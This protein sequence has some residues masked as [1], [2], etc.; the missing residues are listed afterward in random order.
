M[1][2]SHRSSGS[3]SNPLKEPRPSLDSERSFEVG[4]PPTLQNGV[5]DHSTPN[6]VE[7]PHDTDDPVERLQQELSR[8]KEEKDKLASQ[9][10]NLLAKLTQ[11]RTTLGTKLQQDAVSPFSW[12]LNGILDGEGDRQNLTDASNLYN[13]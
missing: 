13:S 7:H 11:M 3:F 9:Y 1:A 5:H 6:G 10:S 8:T 4:S 12:S 2:S